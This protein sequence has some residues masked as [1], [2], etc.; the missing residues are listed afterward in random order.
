MTPLFK[1]LNIKKVYFIVGILFSILSTFYSCNG[2]NNTHNTQKALKQNTTNSNAIELDPKATVIYHDKKDNFWFASIKKGVYKYNGKNL[3]LFTS[4]DGLNSYRILSVQEDT[5]GNIYFDTPEGVYKYN[6]TNF[7]T[8]EVIQN[9]ESENEWKSEPEDLWFRMG[10]NKSGPYRFDGKALHHL[11]LPKNKMEE[12]FHTKY[13]NASYNP[14]GIY[15]IYKDSKDNIWFGTSNLGI[16]LFDGNKI[17]WA[18]ENQLT[19]TPEGG[20]FGIRSIAE[21]RDGNYW[22]CNTNYK[23]TLLPNDTEGS[24][25]KS[26]KFKRQIGIKSKRKDVLY[27]LS[28]QTDSNGDL[29]MLTYQNGVWRNNGKELIPFF[30]KDG[31]SDISPSSIYKDKQNQIWLGTQNDGIYIYNGKTFKKFNPNLK[32]SH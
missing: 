24:D 21:D 13:P 6:G 27:F 14:Y 3:T 4:N 20:D 31:D 12:E 29:L 17:S 19:V 2:H 7:I 28:I 30:I 15:S 8:L 1:K 10:W 22:F 18:Y 26:I 5:S 32:S 16:Y 11:K 9:K 25:L 23:Y